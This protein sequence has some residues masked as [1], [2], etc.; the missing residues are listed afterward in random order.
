MCYQIAKEIGSYVAVLRGEVTRIILTGGGA[1]CPPLVEN[2]SDY[3]KSFAPIHV[4]AGEDE[5]SALA[6]GAL[7]VLRHEVEPHEYSA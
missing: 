3:V 1:K 7:R 6:L 2:V 4:V 5:L